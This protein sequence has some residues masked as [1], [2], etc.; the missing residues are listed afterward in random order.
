MNF[1]GIDIGG[2]KTSICVANSQGEILDRTKLPT[3][4]NTKRQECVDEILAI[5]KRYLSRFE[6]TSIGLSVPG[7]IS[8]KNKKFIAPPNLPGWEDFPIACLIEDSLNK[9]VYFN[10]DANAA[11]LAEY[12]FGNFKECKDLIYLTTSTGMGGGIIAN[13]RLIQGASDTAG[14]VG[15]MVVELHTDRSTGGI[16]GSWESYCGGYAFAQHIQTLL[17]K[18]KPSTT[19][20]Q[21]P[22][23]KIS[24]QE[25]LEA[26]SRN[27]PFS[28]E[29]FL[30]FI[31]RLAQGIAIL[32]MTL[33]PTAIVLGTIAMHA[34]DLIMVPL[35]KALIPLCWKEALDAVTIS[36]SS[37]TNIG[38]L[39]AISLCLY[40]KEV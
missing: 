33:N 25:I 34:G 24:M 39:G 3:L 4:K 2:T 31:E 29:Q 9:P 16:R 32:I 21:Y 17:I 1:L 38:D 8:V 6:I 27:D 7:P 22:L 37:L 23:E 35:K 5:C 13:G 18:E 10:N 26:V 19:L 12:Y 36:P 14:E 28:V 30:I 15:H 11:V 20:N 40:G